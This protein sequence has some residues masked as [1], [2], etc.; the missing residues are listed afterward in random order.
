[1]STTTNFTPTVEEA[2]SDEQILDCYSTIVELRP[3]LNDRQDYLS[4]VRRQQTN[5]G[6]H[7]MFVRDK[8]GNVVSIMGYRV[9]ERLFTGKL[10]NIDDLATLSSARGHGFGGLL[11]KWAIKHAKQ[12][13]CERIILDSRYAEHDTHRFFMTHG[14]VIES[15]H[16]AQNLK[17]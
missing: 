16:L 17:K 7:L 8:S 5:H 9:E 14:F 11:V 1:M 13:D 10:F 6:Y 4:R 3:H 2:K 12:L 15:H